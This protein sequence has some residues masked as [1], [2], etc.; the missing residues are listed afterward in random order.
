MSTRHRSWYL[1]CIV[2]LSMFLAQ[3]ES[4]GPAR[5]GVNPW[6]NDFELQPLE[7]RPMLEVRYT[8]AEREAF[9]IV[10]QEYHVIGQLRKPHLLRDAQ[11]DE[12]W[13]K[14]SV[15]DRAGR[16]YT[17]QF[18]RSRSRINLYR[19]GPYFCEV[20]WLDITLAGESGKT[21]PLKG[22]LAL[23]CYPHKMLASVTWHPTEALGSHD[24]A[25]SGEVR[26]T[27]TTQ[28]F[29]VGRPQT[30]SFA[31]FGEEPPLPESSLKTIQ[32]RT[33]LKYDPV[34]GCYTIG[35][36]NPG[37]FQPHFYH[38]PN[39][40]ETV[41][42]QIDND[43]RGRVVYICHETVSGSAGQVEGGVLL[44]AEGDPLPVTV[45]ISKNFSGE[46]EEKFYN[47]EDTAF[48]ETYFPLVLG[49]HESCTISSLHLYQNW[50]RHMVK[51]F[52]SLGAWMDY[53]H[54]S[55]GVTET[56]CYVPFKYAG[57][58]GID[59][60]DFR[61]MSQSAF[62]GGQ[63]QHD[64]IA[65]HSFLS[66]KDSSEW[67]Y[68]AYRG[69]TYSSTGPNWMDIRLDQLSS[70]KK[71]R[72]SVRTFE[73]PQK[74][75]LRNFL[76]VRYE[77][78]QP[79]TIE[80][81][82][83]NFRLLTV[84]TWVQRLR[85]THFAASGAWDTKLSFDKDHFGVLGQGLP[86][87]PCFAAMYGEGKGSNAILLR[88]WSAPFKPAVSVLCQK[89]GDTR[90]M[91]VP[92][93]DKLTLEPG[94]TIEFE[95]AFLPYGE[96][97]GARTPKREVIAYG[98]QA[99]RVTQVLSGQ[100]IGD[101]P[102]VIRAH[103]DRAEFILQGGRDLIPVIVTGLTDYREPRLWQKKQDGWRMLSHA[104][105]GQKDGVQVFCSTDQ[106]FGA[107]F[108]VASDDT[109]QHLRVTLGQEIQMPAR[110][111]VEP[112]EQGGDSR[113]PVALIQAPW[114]QA[115]IRLHFPASVQVGK[116]TLNLQ[117]AAPAWKQDADGSLWF[118]QNVG[119]HLIGG[120]LS[121]NEED[122]DLEFWLGNRGKQELSCSAKFSPMLEGTE[123]ADNTWVHRHEGWQR[124]SKMD[125]NQADDD[126]DRVAAVSSDGKYL[127]CL[128]WPAPTVLVRDSLSPG[129][130]FDPVLP[131][132]PPGKRVHIRGELYL[133]RGSLD[134]LDA[135][136]RREVLR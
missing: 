74:D 26:H 69:T 6:T 43:D 2:G 18:S 91:L 89:S 136:A 62:W 80:R 87:P 128:A 98:I 12:L 110:I 64:N 97:D 11:S 58:K 116:H 8:D 19:R 84:A 120:R 13:L 40:Y 17:G 57:L 53:F 32:G 83:E 31:L 121:P 109:A 36:H 134:E 114:M 71:I 93:A 76:H 9:E 28:P 131:P 35:S 67:R 39:H 21:M 123:F 96:I 24:F 132:C 16:V 49:P 115:P 15:T 5:G 112:Q 95:A 59:I 77:V 107:V 90:L 4:G 3:P 129:V 100:R 105:A 135:R 56:T 63:P 25:V 51:Q 68:M 124:L 30:F 130:H 20:H 41:Q 14:L 133:M 34:R 99:P 37:A 101:F 119:G 125:K 42:L 127:F 126:C 54:S 45:Q 73:L 106:E 104:R 22:D 82:R 10:A 86:F 66:Y 81:A 48:S 23:Y 75:E 44:D 33:P 122:V 27:F 117:S 70:D 29:V 65:G 111:T 102:T 7:H 92:D 79:I 103:N 94:D 60:A 118:E 50:G 52:S 78:L 88:S 108:L 38:H 85:Y 113:R 46:K 55:T 47:P 61:A 72:G 1:T